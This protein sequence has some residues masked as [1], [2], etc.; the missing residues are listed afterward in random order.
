MYETAIKFMWDNTGQYYDGVDQSLREFDKITTRLD[1][2]RDQS[3]FDVYPEHMNIRH[4]IMQ[5][6][7]GS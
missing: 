1:D 3:F 2:I 7:L 6:K 5:N 4:Y